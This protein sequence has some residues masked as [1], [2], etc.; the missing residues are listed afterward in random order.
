MS[1]D[2]LADA[3]KSHLQVYFPSTDF[4]YLLTRSVGELQNSLGFSFR[5]EL[6]AEGKGTKT[7][8]FCLRADLKLR[9]C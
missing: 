7:Y 1:F 4:L 5:Q 9:P 3:S 2:R 6:W 8:F